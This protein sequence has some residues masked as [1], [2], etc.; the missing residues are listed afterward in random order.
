MKVR[1]AL[2]VLVALGLV[3]I[4]GQSKALALSTITF[5]EGGIIAD[6]TTDPG[7]TQDPVSFVGTGVGEIVFSAGSPALWEDTIVVGFTGL[8]GNSLGNGFVGLD[9][10][11]NV[12]IYSLPL[13]FITVA[14]DIESFLD[15]DLV[16]EGYSG[17]GLVASNTVT[18]LANDA[19]WSNSI[20]LSYADGMTA[21]RFYT[22][23]PTQQLF[24]ID[25]FTY[26]VIPEPA[27]FLLILSC[28]GG[29][30]LRRRRRR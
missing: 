8:S 5:D 27:T 4:V 13:T 17:G 7:F 14:F 29:V 16:L 11:I 2:L 23:D 30:A 21:L 10:V 18:D 1:K 6:V 25:D 22:Q 20:S 15:T 19:P 3:V 28:L 9:S 12:D 24:Y 26:E